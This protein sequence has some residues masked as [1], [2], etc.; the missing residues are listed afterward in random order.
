MKL[1]KQAVIILMLLNL[2]GCWSK[3]ELDELTFIYGLY[4]DVGKE[5][6]TVEVSISSPL[7]NRL[8]SGTQAG[9]G[10]GDGK[11]YTLVSKTARTIQ[12]AT[13]M[14]QKDLSR[15]LEI[16]HIKIV[17]LGK[18]YAQQGIGKV[19][20]WFERK[21]E[22]PLDTYIMAAPGKAKDI[23]KLTPVFEQNPDQVLMNIAN[24]NILF[25][26]SVKD[27]LL[28][29]A[30]DM[31]YAMNYLSFGKKE[32]T[33]EQGKTEYWAGVQGVM[34][35]QDAKMKGIL[36][37]KQSRA[38]AWGAG[39]LAGRLELPEYTITWDEEGKGSASAIFQSNS[40][41]RTVKMTSEGP[42]FQIK[43]KGRASIT[44]LEDSEGRSVNDLSPLIKR[45]LQERIVK[46]ISNS[47]RSVQEAQI[48]V[49]QLGMVV[50]W[51]YPKAWNKLR[52]RWYDYYANAEIKVTADFTI[53]DFGSER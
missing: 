33:S 34:L 13:I 39:R 25:S 3:V 14:I 26:T 53:E 20:E 10:T 23:F 29:E 21:P 50:E 4:I 52:E 47:V 18:E 7:P 42:V 15:H 19:L 30:S 16:S 8:M 48:D 12:D 36:D 17:V 31:G 40:A 44:F 2:T 11:A 35:F 27:C 51:K 9:S 22:F 28:A 43:V 5:P 41:S 45:K 49:L 38:L 46:E 6:G 37:V 32:E 1:I 24:E